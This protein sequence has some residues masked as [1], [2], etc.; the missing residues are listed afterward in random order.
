MTPELSN[1]LAALA[2]RLGTTVEQL[3][4]MLVARQRL[5]AILGLVFGV[6]VA[7][8]CAFGCWKAYTKK[9]DR[10]DEDM[11]IKWLPIGILGPIGVVAL[12]I[13]VGEIPNIVFPE[14]AAIKS[15]IPGK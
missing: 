3:W 4:P 15:L 6:F 10:F 5:G 8:I 12:G 13:S 2:N 7:A 9:Y 11:G 14:I 1:T